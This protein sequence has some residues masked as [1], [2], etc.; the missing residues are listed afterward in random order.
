MKENFNTLNTKFEA[1]REKGWIM[2]PRKGFGEVGM[3]FE[4]ELGLSNNDFPI[5][6]FNGI[7][8]KVKNKNSN[9]PISL[10]SCTCDGP[11][12]YELKRI[13]Q[14]FGICYTDNS[15][16]KLLYITLSGRY[17]SYWGKYLKMKL[18]VD[19]R[20]KKVYILISHANGKIIEKRAFW[21][22]STLQ[23]ILER[24][25][26][27][28]CVVT[29]ESS[30]I[31]KTRFTRFINAEY[32]KLRN[33]DKFIELIENGMIFVNIKF[34]VYKSGQ[35]KGKSYDHGTAFQ[36]KKIALYNLYEKFDF[37]QKK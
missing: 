23:G 8:I 17:F 37:K 33:F 19:R 14:K 18:H 16:T 30:F 29:S 24:K 15:D 7:E 35:K 36:I 6:D 10:F 9:Y 11:E 26:L 31:N 4:K 27:F 28:L 1:I 13:V 32:L 3:K 20:K 22:F 25:L 21:E 12:L 5:A 34:G 2:I